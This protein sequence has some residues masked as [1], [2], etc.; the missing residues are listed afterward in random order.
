MLSLAMGANMFGKT[1]KDWP[2][3]RGQKMNAT[4]AESDVFPVSGGFGLK[5]AWKRSLGSGYSSVSVFNGHAV[6]MFSDGTDDQ[7]I[8]FDARTGKEE[9]RHK[10]APSYDGHDGSH[11][12]PIST[13][14][15]SG[16]MV[17]VL[18][19]KGEL[20]ALD[21]QSGRRIWS[22]HLADDLQAKT[23]FYGFATSPLLDGDILMVETGG[24][25]ST[26]SGFD[27]TT[28]KLLWHTG[29]DTVN[30]QSPI[31]LTLGGKKQLLC[32]GDKYLYG[33]EPA[34]GK[35]L[36]EYRHN[37]GGPSINPVM[38]G[39]NK[40]FL[41]YKWQESVLLE[42]SEQNGAFQAQELWKNRS[43]RGTYNT[44]VY[45]DGYLYGY[46]N[47]FLT[48][49]DAET[50]KSVW[51]SRQPG[52]GFLIL[53]DG[54][55][56]LI[57]KKGSLHVAKASPEKYEEL[58]RLDLFE[59]LA[60]APPSFA[61]GKIYARSLSEIACV[62]I[63]DMQPA[64]AFVHE[65]LGPASKFAQF[66]RA[67]EAAGDKT[68]RIEAFM[69]FQKT[70]P[71]IETDSLVH[72]VYRGDAKDVALS[73]DM[74]GFRLDQP[75]QHIT[76]TDFFYDS[77]ILEPDA[78]V[79]Y[80]FI[81]DFDKTVADSM[82]TR[83]SRSFMGPTSWVAMPNWRVPAHLEPPVATV[84]TGRMDSLHLVSKI[85]GTARTLDIYLPPGYDKG[86][87][88]Y[89]V[90]YVHNGTTALK[91]GK[92]KNTLDNLIGKS[93]SPLI[94]VFIPQLPRSRGQEF[95]GDAKENYAAMVSDEIVP[96][97]DRTYRTIPEPRERAVMG[98][99]DAG[100][101][102][103]FGSFTKPGVFGK[104]ASQSAFLLTSQ[105]N[106]LYALLRN[107]Q[108]PGVQIYLDWG[109]YDIQS[110]LEGWSIAAANAKLGRYLTEH[111]Y[112]Y[113]GGEV[114]EGFGWGS[115][116]NRTDKI[117]EAFFPLR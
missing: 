14:V 20:L 41:Q 69:Q 12:G 30:Y 19:P 64:A 93:V 3:W 84:A 10:I 73:G 89:P 49:I 17:Y 40:I 61:N 4:A 107:T 36:W 23:P 65:T 70:F 67:V 6:T 47:R 109:K 97:I 117:L 25:G 22:T 7:V 79:E 1:K 85:T 27:R 34:T 92:M 42:I 55:L 28:G 59:K 48:C 60:W 51:K 95:T 100:F 101:G 90:A 96:L 80:R 115:W 105:E 68:A 112:A 53:V 74:I 46:S 9:W 114:N 18:G 87:T 99:G 29:R 5:L 71:I 39:D 72:F 37:G 2:Q 110:P 33:I 26:V 56:V 24:P 88:K 91:A 11:D 44:A 45:S 113:T 81:I 31:T 77:Q 98:A 76:G 86:E 38:A 83:Y 15:V 102:A 75:M 35:M 103:M 94:V 66:V 50:G 78:R 111:K 104:I 82:N 106:A 13:P 63:V 116:R 54:H 43:I 52:D 21:L 8:S 58:A 32:I 57:T 108:Q 62:Q 16:G